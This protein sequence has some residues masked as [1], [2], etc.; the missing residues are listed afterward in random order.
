MSHCKATDIHKQ[1]QCTE[2]Q[3]FF[4]GVPPA[5]RP[6]DCVVRRC[7]LFTV[8]AIVTQL[9]GRRRQLR[10]SDAANA[11]AMSLSKNAVSPRV[12]PSC[13]IDKV[14][15]RWGKASVGEDGV[16]WPVGLSGRPHLCDI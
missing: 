4:A 13:F 8:V 2:I 9:I 12:S 10:L 15:K 1:L 5:R 7:A 6:A 3:V 11:G 14:W 16:N